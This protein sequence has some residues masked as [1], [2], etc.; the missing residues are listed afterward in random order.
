MQ[1]IWNMLKKRRF[2]I[3]RRSGNDRRIA[4][5]P[6]HL[7]HGGAERRTMKERRFKAERRAGWMR[8]NDWYSIPQ[9]SISRPLN[10]L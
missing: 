7:L 9:Q 1:G 5:N 8:L 10:P 3:D 4:Y 2:A 6:D